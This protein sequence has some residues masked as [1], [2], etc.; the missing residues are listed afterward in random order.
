M[1]WRE[2]DWCNE[3]LSQLREEIRETDSRILALIKER[4]SI[5]KKIG[6]IK[7]A[8]GLSIHDTEQETRVIETRLKEGHDLGL[9]AD[10]VNDLMVLLMKHSKR[11]QLCGTAR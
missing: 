10:F 2:Y 5:C 6:E 7:M 8:F 3:H 9:D 4:M 1:R 11:L